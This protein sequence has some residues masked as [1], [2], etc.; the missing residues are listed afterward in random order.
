MVLFKEKKVTQMKRTYERLLFMAL[1]A[2]ISFTAYIIGCVSHTENIQAQDIG[3]KIIRCDQ[4]I[5]NDKILVGGYPGAI[6][7]SKN[8]DEKLV[9]LQIR[10]GVEESNSSSITLGTNSG[11]SLIL[12]KDSLGEKELNTINSYEFDNLHVKKSLIVGGK[13]KNNVSISGGD[14]PGIEIAHSRTNPTSSIF[15]TASHNGVG[16]LLED[17][18]GKHLITSQ[19][20]MKTLWLEEM[21]IVGNPSEEFVVISTADLQP[22]ISLIKGSLDNPKSEIRMHINAN[23]IP[24]IGLGQYDGKYKNRIIL[25]ADKR[26]S[27]AILSDQFGSKTITTTDMEIMKEK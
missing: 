5:V 15:L 13:T 25:S 19:N 18:N 23:D 22:Y 21:L 1:G 17:Y 3:K 12:L 4:L 27:A 24:M 16:I 6:L 2:L 20:K 11:R 8:V 26:N 14:I 7:L 9:G 10:Y